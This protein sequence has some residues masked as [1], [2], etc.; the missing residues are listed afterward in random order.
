M[1]LAFQMYWHAQET[2]RNFADV[3][4]RIRKSHEYLKEQLPRGCGV[5]VRK[6]VV[7]DYAD[8]IPND[9]DWDEEMEKTQA[10][11]EGK[12]DD[13]AHDSGMRAKVR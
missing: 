9:Y 1:W 4:E 13:N 11:P 2:E 3:R 10:L 8:G 6:T 5:N 12:L 7:V